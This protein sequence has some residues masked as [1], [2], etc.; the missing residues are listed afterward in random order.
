MIAKAELWEQLQQEK[1][2]FFDQHRSPGFTSPRP[3]VYDLMNQRAYDWMRQQM[4]KRLSSYQGHYPWWT[5]VQWRKERPK[6]DLR[7]WDCELHYFPPEQLAVRLELVLPDE[8]V[9]CSDFHA[10][11]CIL[12]NEYVARTDAEAEPWEQL[13]LVH[14]KRELIEHSWETIFDLDESHW[15][16]YRYGERRIQGCFEELR[17]EQVKQVTYFRC[18]YPKGNSQSVLVSDQRAD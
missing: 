3:T 5:W 18:R 11:C 9:L 1:H 8:Q 12:F 7:S 16:E 17:I 10:W 15:D 2:L 6:P 4:T 14:H 13:A